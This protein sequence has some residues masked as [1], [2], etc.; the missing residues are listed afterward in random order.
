MFKS[1]Y[2]I[3]LDQLVYCPILKSILELRASMF[4]C[5]SWTERSINPKADTDVDEYIKTAFEIYE[6]IHQGG[7]RIKCKKDLQ[8]D[9]IGL[10]I[11]IRKLLMRFVGEKSIDEQELD[12]QSRRQVRLGTMFQVSRHINSHQRNV[13]RTVE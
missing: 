9:L 13:H 8:G 7:N 1:A 10:K 3:L 12:K 5:Y 6:Q 2:L 4:A 11:K